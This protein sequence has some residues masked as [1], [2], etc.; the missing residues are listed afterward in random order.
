[1]TR[2]APRPES[3]F[4][5][6]DA[7]SEDLDALIALSRRTFSEKFGAAY[8]EEDLRTYLDA[9]HSAKFYKDAL[10]D[11]DCLVRVAETRDGALAAYLLCSP[12][13]LP[14]DDP[15]PGSVEL[16]RVYVDAPLQG[17]GAGTAF[18]R[19]AIFWARAQGAPDLYLSVYSENVG[20]LKLYQRHGWQKVSEFIFMVGQTQDL[21]YLM[22]LDLKAG[23]PGD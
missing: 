11:P 8:P 4:A 6:R 15:R 23:S 12:L 21:E 9:H 14:A 1:M 2:S 20:A 22:R 10:S 3:G 19:E 17:K 13:T 5:L 18:I 16:K 7:R